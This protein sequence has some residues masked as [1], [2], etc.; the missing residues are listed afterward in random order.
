MTTSSNQFPEQVIISSRSLDEYRAQ[1]SLTDDDLR[2]KILD[3]PG[4]AAELTAVVS[5]RGGD[6]TACDVAYFGDGLQRLAEN[7]ATQSDVGTDYI[8]SHQDLYEWTLFADPDSVQRVRHQA[9]AQ[10][11]AHSREHPERYIAGKLP[12][13]PFA[14]NSFDLV[15]SSTL[16]FCYAHDFDY[17]FHVAAITELMRVTRDELRIYPL[18]PVGTTT[19]YPQMDRL[20]ADLTTRDIAGQ[21]VDVDFRFQRGAHHMLVCRPTRS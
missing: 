16:L 14:D 9:G 2:R 15:L 3:C 17:D 6:A 7:V 20:L 4:G 11:A 12:D 10:F 1:F 5:N 21:I 18:V 8:R 13:L 19:L